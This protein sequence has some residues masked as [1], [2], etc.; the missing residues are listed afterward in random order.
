VLATAAQNENQRLL[1]GFFTSVNGRSQN[2]IARVN[3]DGSL[4]ESFAHGA[5]PNADVRCLAIQQDGRILLA[6]GFTQFNAA[7]CGRIIRLET[8]GT[9]DS[10]FNTGSGANGRIYDLRL[11]ANGEILIV[12]AFTEFNG[13]PRG[14]I[15]RLAANGSLL[16]QY[17]AAGAQNSR[18]GKIKA[19]GVQSDGK[20]LLGGEFTEVAGREIP[21]IARLNADGSLDAAFDPG[22]GVDGYVQGITVQ[23]DGKILVAGYFGSVNGSGRTSLARLNA[24]GSLDDVFNPAVLKLDG[25]LSILRKPVVCADSKILVLGHFRSVNGQSRNYVA[26]IRPDGSLDA[27][28]D[29]QINILGWDPLKPGVTLTGGSPLAN[30]AEV[31]PDGKVLVGGSVVWDGLGRGYLTRLDQSGKMDDSFL[32]KSVA[33]NAVITAG[34][35]NRVL[36]LFDGKILVCGGFVEIKDG[37]LWSAPSRGRIARFDAN[38]LLDDTFKP[39]MGADNSIED[40]ALQSDGK[41]LICGSFR[42]YDVEY[43]PA[44]TNAVR[45]ARLNSNGSLDPSF[46]S[47]GGPE[48]TAYSIAWLSS[49]RA[50]VTGD[51]ATYQGVARSGIARIVAASTNS[52]PAGFASWAK[53]NFLATDPPGDRAAAADPDGDGVVNVLEYAFGMNPKAP[54]RS[55]LPKAGL[56]QVGNQTYLAL[57]YLRPKTAP[58]DLAYEWQTSTDLSNWQAVGGVDVGGSVPQGERVA[59]TVRPQAPVTATPGGFYRLR[60]KQN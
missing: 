17:T 31:L 2:R 42:N 16:D 57:T 9:V 54:D 41:I 8:D 23:P 53:N 26:R 24:D 32:P 52:A 56:L 18:P 30:S 51:F 10:S 59:V 6:G 37:S 4:D 40:M 36:A 34:V 29:A 19:V 13:A 12:G 58:A 55:G 46:V 43:Y 28:F 11:R 21:G 22:A 38:G 5:G 7:G 39:V 50:I 48:K 1:A 33:T 35:V 45:V 49:D 15:A 60:V 27:G 14:G 47:T 25:S 20:I 3:K 44:P